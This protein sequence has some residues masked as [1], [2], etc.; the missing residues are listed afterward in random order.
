VRARRLAVV[1]LTSIL[2]LSGGP[3]CRRDPAKPDE[4]STKPPPAPSPLSKALEI[5]A[6]YATAPLPNDLDDPAIW[7]HPSDPARSLILGTMKVA[8]PAGALVVFGLDGQIR[9]IV[10]GIDRPN[11]VDVEYGFQFAGS[12]V[13]V[14]VVTERL[15]RQLRVFRI[16]PTEGRLVDLG[17]SP[18]LQDQEG[19]NG[20]PMGIGLYR[21]GRDGAIFAIVAP[22]AGPREGYLWQYRLVDAGGG[23][24]GATFIRRFG[25]FS[26]STVREENE[27]EAV[28]VDDAL[29]YVYYA[30]E[31]DGIHKW[32]ADPDHHDAGRELAHFAR[33]GFRGDRE[34]IAIYAFPDGTGYIV[35]TDQLD[36]DSEYHVYAREGAPGNPH[37]HSREIAVLRGGADATDGLEISSSA[38]GPGLRNGVMIAMNSA[39][40]NFLVFRWQDVAA[41][42]KPNLRMNG[43]RSSPE[44]SRAPVPE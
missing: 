13:D 43:G 3:A 4:D 23:R 31:A 11:N 8:A 41:A 1:A 36:E 20:A 30:D 34:G 14:A 5:E 12:R 37:D 38:F 16:D 9:Q 18:I 24:I 26:A 21:R 6:E 40:Q 17:G 33:D 7:V 32:H 42:V 25:R 29:G 22:K 35:C 15:S 19:E 28:A 44:G 39:A 10:S 27:I 2:I